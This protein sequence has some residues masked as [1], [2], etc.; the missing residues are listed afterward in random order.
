MDTLV[1]RTQVGA[2]AVDIVAPVRLSAEA[3]YSWAR[4][5]PC[6]GSGVSRHPDFVVAPGMELVLGLKGERHSL[7]MVVRVL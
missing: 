3:A 6:F 7:R 4:L 2:S 5:R 1:A